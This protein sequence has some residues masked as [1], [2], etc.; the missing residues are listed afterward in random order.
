MKQKI[1][2]II[3]LV[4]MAFSVLAL[5]SCERLEGLFPG[6]EVTD[7]HFKNVDMPLVYEIYL[8]YMEDIDEEPLSYDE[9]FEA[10]HGDEFQEGI[11]P[12]I[13]KNENSGF[14]EISFNNG[15]GWNDLRFKTENEEQ[16]KCKQT[17]GKWVTISE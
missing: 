12:L 8:D 3:M 4:V 14:W 5:S 2:G 1:L 11:I 6:G 7:N 10:I 17:F 9:W 16:K 13:E 15:K